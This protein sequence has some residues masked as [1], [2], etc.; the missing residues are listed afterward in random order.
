[1]SSYDHTK[2][3]QA[4]SCVSPNLLTQRTLQKVSKSTVKLSQTVCTDLKDQLN[5]NKFQSISVATQTLLLAKNYQLFYSHF[6][7][8]LLN[9]IR[10]I[11]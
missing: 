2:L 6:L 3:I 4:N 10:A 8:S 11:I 9:V 7:L 5:V 1:M